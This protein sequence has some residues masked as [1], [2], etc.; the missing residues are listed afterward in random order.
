MEKYS[1][2][3]IC[4][5]WKVFDVEP[6]FFLTPALPDRW[7]AA[8]E[9]RGTRL[10]DSLPLDSLHLDS[11]HLDSLHLDSL[12]LDSPLPESRIAMRAAAGGGFVEGGGIHFFSLVLATGQAHR[13]FL[14]A[15]RVDFFILIAQLAQ[16][17]YQSL[18]RP[19]GW[20]FES[21]RRRNIFSISALRTES[22]V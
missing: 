1:K 17:G 12:L 3:T 13:V 2:S 8:D 21:R 15:L 6:E 11:L 9:G 18:N 22:G 19:K 10:L 4:R 5:T 14:L 16:K 7:S 20:V